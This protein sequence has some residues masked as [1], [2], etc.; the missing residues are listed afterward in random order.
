MLD[1]L[2]KKKII[3]WD[4]SLY[5]TANC[6][7]ESL[8]QGVDFFCCNP[9]SSGTL[10]Q[11][12]YS[13]GLMSELQAE[14]D[15]LR[16]FSAPVNIDMHNQKYGGWFGVIYVI[17]KVRGQKWKQWKCEGPDLQIVLKSPLSFFLIPIRNRVTDPDDGEG[18]AR[19]WSL[20]R[21]SHGGK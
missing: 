15:H 17:S 1:C 5:T 13:V 8:K 19:W 6:W 18:W 12:I 2:T 3:M 14:E 4:Y 10:L 11:F 21:R 9:C 7:E 20:N 16:A